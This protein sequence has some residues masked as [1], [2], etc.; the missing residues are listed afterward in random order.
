[1]IDSIL[2]TICYFDL[3]DYPLTATEIWR[4]YYVSP[5]ASQMTPSLQ[6]IAIALET[7]SRLQ[8]LLIRREGFYCLTG[9]EKIITQ[10]KFRNSAVD[11]QMRIAFFWTKVFRLIPWVR[12]VA[13]ASSL[14]LG[15]VKEKSDIDFFIVC[16]KG[17]VWITRFLLVGLLKLSRQRP[18]SQQT[19]NKICLS[20]YVTSEALSL[21]TAQ[22][23]REDIVFTH[24]VAGFL[25]LY[26]AGGVYDAWYQANSWYRYFLP[27]MGQ[28][29][30]A[31]TVEN[32]PWLTLWHR[33]FLILIAPF[34]NSLTRDW[35]TRMQLQILPDRL[36]S[37]AN[38]DGRVIITENV[39][40]FHD[41]DN[42]LP[43]KNLWQAKI[44]NL[45]YAQN[46]IS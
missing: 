2:K 1:M 21:Q 7:D 6:E 22:L 37:L 39:L 26:D 18:S 25:P 33:L 17:H 13:V 31:F 28:H 40:K 45:S 30:T 41:K 36:K 9:R 24:Y 12:M 29:G 44:K 19:K 42:R 10:R 46:N 20:Y 35:Y 38:I 34:Y 43:M 27:N 14:P 11:K 3:L 16:S 32:P 8:K 4:W 15:N 5:S 23:G